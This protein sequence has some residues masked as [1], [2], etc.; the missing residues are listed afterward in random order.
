MHST[1]CTVSATLQAHLIHLASEAEVIPAIDQIAYAEAPGR[2]CDP[3][4]G[5]CGRNLGT[6]GA[7]RINSAPL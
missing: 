2:V 4:G 6:V 7:V 3:A 1:C 5:L